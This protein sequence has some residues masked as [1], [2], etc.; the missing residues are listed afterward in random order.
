MKKKLWN[1]DW[2]FYTDSDPSEQK[3]ALPHDAMLQ[4]TR[5][6]KSKGK[7]AVGYFEGDVYHYK[8]NFCISKEEGSHH[9]IQFDGVYQNTTVL[10]NGRELCT[11]HYGYTPFEVVLDPA[12]SYTEENCLEVIADNSMLPNS[13]W[14]S[15]GG[16]Y[17]DVTFLSSGRHYIIPDGIRVD[18]VS[19]TPPVIRI[20]TELSIP[21]TNNEVLELQIFD[22]EQI[23]AVEVGTD[24]T[25]SLPD[26]KLWSDDSPKLYR[27]RAVLKQENEILDTD[28][29]TFGIR[30]ITYSTE[31]FF[32]NGKST[33]LRG[34]CIHH[35]NGILGACSYYDAELRKI[36]T[37]KS[38]GFNA[39]RIAHNPASRVLL[40]ACDECG[41][42]VMDEAFDMWFTNKNKYD[43]ATYFM[44]DYLQDITAMVHHDYNHP[45]VIMY[46]IGN[47]VGEPSR[48]EGLD[49]AV[50]MRD[51]IHQLD[52]SRPVTAGIN[53]M[54][55]MLS[56]MGKGLYDEGGLAASNSAKAPDE[57]KSSKKEKKSGSLMF[58]TM[59]T[60]MGKGI[61]RIGNT[62]KADLAASPVLD[63]L[64]ISGYNYANGRYKKEA[65][66]HPDRIILGSETYPQDIYDNWKQVKELPYL[67]GDFMW[68]AWDYLG[69]AAIGSW[70]YEGISMTNIRYPW[71]LSCAG[72]VDI[73]GL[74]DAQAAYAGTVWG[75]RSSP[76]IGV[77]PIN[78]PGIRVTKAAW[79]GTNAI[80]SWSWRNC[81]G[82]T[83][84]IE[85]CSTDHTAELILNGKRLARKKLRK[86]KAQFHIPYTPGR[87]VV[88]TYNEQGLPVNESALVSA[89]PDLS[90]HI[91]PEPVLA[92]QDLI[93]IRL[94]IADEHG[95]VE[96]NA[97]TTLTVT[98]ENGTL[99]GLGS[100]KPDPVL[101]YTGNEVETYYGH[102]LAI[103]KTTTEHLPVLHVTLPDGQH[104]M[105]DL[106]RR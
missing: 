36:R 19:C 84:L 74:P 34:G 5:S 17:R 44:E 75:I 38:L 72:V 9:V 42:Y 105:K 91:D 59:M 18:T 10:L 101:S 104:F 57:P 13:R 8:K 79:R 26:A 2:F 30:M 51:L 43:Y 54:I 69:E 65:V 61:N 35:D 47:E 39:V 71:L 55:L 67:I 106:N 95:I 70:N 87:L 28:E 1:E 20:R 58:N 86:Q 73:T 52:P 49:V 23:L 37:L 50:K 94:T 60:V 89:S 4:G 97:D 88:K 66:K 21:L 98:V 6:P 78:H 7:D 85:V 33:L 15:G 53:F 80:D 92:A 62:K 81:D 77:R 27:C 11:H 103:V 96:S 24:C 68:T 12:L 83:A 46:S 14:Y 29:T 45:S 3:I 93:Y 32:V 90:V 56:S 76:Y 63:L 41:M 25:I 82:N 22:D 64:D 40:K 99:L 16:I 100:A 48:P 102:A 31:G